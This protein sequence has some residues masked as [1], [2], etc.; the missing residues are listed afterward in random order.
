[1]IILWGKGWLLRKGVCC[2]VDRQGD[3]FKYVELLGVLG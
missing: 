2:E 3:F 1:M